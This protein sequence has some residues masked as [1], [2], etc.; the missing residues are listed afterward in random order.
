MTKNME[1]ITN[2]AKHRGFVFPGSEIYG[3]L[4]NTWDYGPLGVE[5]KNNVKKAWWKKFVQESPYNVG[6]DAAI[7]MNPRTWEASGHIGNF[8]DPMMDCKNCKARHRADKL[9]EDAAEQAGK[10]IIVDGLPF[11]KMEE[12]VKEYNIACPE[13]GSH[14]FT[15]IRQFNLMFKTHQGVT[16]SSS[17]EIYMRPETAQGIFVNFKNVQRTM[18]KKLPFGIAQIGKSFRNEI[19][20][21][22]FT[23]RTR[24]FEQME[25]EF[26]CKPGSEIEWFNY[27]KDTA[28]NWLKSLGMTSE[29]LR[30]RDH[31]EDELSHYSNATTDFEYKFP[32]GWGELWGVA[33]RTDFDLKRHMEFSG[34]DFNYIDQETN[35]RYVP[36]CIEPS[37]GADRV[38][39]AFLIDAYEDE[40]LEDGTSRTVMHLHPALAPYK[41]AILPLSKKL[42][43]EATE[44]FSSLAKDFNVDYDETGSI[45]KRYRRQDEVGTPFCITYDFDSK[46][47][48]MVTVRDRDTMEQT[49]VK[50]ADLKSFIES[51]VQF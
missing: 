50:I 1:T 4:A 49:R 5:L 45:G 12:L 30:L 31:N 8:N 26:F 19:T 51:K 15:S 3:G 28:E 32:F 48:G 24:E 9:I 2:H 39:L 43:E 35:E 29:N 20:P 34:E 46:E 11:E 17:N 42:S 23:F 21:G 16:E 36:Y 41:A 14:D 37:L 47:D 27:W 10:E 25:L 22:N 44:V 6:L 7:L 38:T 13:C 18:R 40:Q 33:S